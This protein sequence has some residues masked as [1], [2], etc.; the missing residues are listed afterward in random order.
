M[1][2]S[3]EIQEQMRNKIV[4]MYQSG[5]G[6]KAISKALGLQQTMVR[7]I[8]HK[9]RKL[10]TVVNLPRSERPTKI[11]PRAQWWLIQEV[12]KE[13]RTTS[14]EPQALLASVKVSVHD[15]T[16]RKTLGKNGIHEKV[17]RQKPLLTK[18]NT[19]SSLTFAKKYPQDY[20]QDF[21]ANILW[22]DETKVELFGRCVSHYIWSKTNTGFHQK[23]IIPTVKHGGGSVMV[24][25]CFAD[26]GSGRLAIID[27]TMNS[28]LYQ[29]ILKENVQPSVCDLKL[30]RTWVMQQ[31]WRKQNEGFGV[32]KSK[33]RLKSDWDAVAWP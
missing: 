8:I 24:W 7:A 26:S 29:K 33:S 27:G 18:Q 30:K 32:A 15:S 25:G 31:E 22:N 1:L 14:K 19:K 2:R 3:K 6:Y 10:G 4:D 28:A 13:P 23:N 16:I 17:P 9:W 11:T 5:K 20:P 21:W 12:I